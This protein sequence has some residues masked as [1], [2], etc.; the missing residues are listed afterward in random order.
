MREGLYCLVSLAIEPIYFM[1]SSEID[2]IYTTRKRSMQRSSA[3][4]AL[5]G[6]ANESPAESQTRL[7]VGLR[8]LGQTFFLP[9]QNF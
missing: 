5:S 1:K 2:Q 4:E 3:N 8:N 6:V 7:D 9:F